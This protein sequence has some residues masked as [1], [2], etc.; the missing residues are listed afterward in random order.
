[1][2]CKDCEYYEKKEFLGQGNRIADNDYCE[3]FEKRL[4]SLKTC[5]K[6]DEIES[7]W[8]HLL[9][10]PVSFSC[11]GIF[12]S[13][14]QLVMVGWAQSTKISGYST[15]ILIVVSVVW[16]WLLFHFENKKVKNLT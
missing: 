2:N 1:M 16:S 11:A 7:I 4:F 5:K 10:L 8:S 12:I 6:F 13:I 3:L 9:I 14:L 15:L